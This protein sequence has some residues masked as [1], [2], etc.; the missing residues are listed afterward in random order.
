MIVSFTCTPIS[1]HIL[2]LLPYQFCLQLVWSS[3]IRNLS[4]SY[5]DIVA[6]MY[7]F[8]SWMGIYVFSISIYIL[9]NRASRKNSVTE[10]FTLYKYIW[11]E[12]KYEYPMAWC[13][14]PTPKCLPKGGTIHVFFFSFYIRYCTKIFSI[15]IKNLMNTLLKFHLNEFL[16]LVILIRAWF[17]SVGVTIL[18]CECSLRL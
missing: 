12:K 13:F 14:C 7:G 18:F 17:F 10:W 4:Q 5:H 11:N 8:Y 9:C 3:H 15:Y 6:F 1:Y 2:M 16:S